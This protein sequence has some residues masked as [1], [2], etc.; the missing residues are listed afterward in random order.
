[1]VV[2]LE[3]GKQGRPG[4]VTIAPTDNMR[5]TRVTSGVHERELIIVG[6]GGFS[7]EAAEAARAA[8][9]AGAPWRLA[10]FVDD[11]EHLAGTEIDGVPVLGRVDDV[12]ARLDSV[13]VV[14]VGRPDNYTARLRIVEH[15]ALAP[16]RYATIVHPAASFGDSTIIGPG[17]VALAGVVATAAVRIGAHVALMPGV[18]LT[19]DNLIGDY[20]TLASGVKLGGGVHI[21][22]GAYLGAG[23]IVR[24]NVTIGPWAMVGMGSIVTRDVP[25]G[26]LWLGTPARFHRPAPV[27]ASVLERVS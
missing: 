24:E 7:R 17:S 12:R 11:A 9:R 25:A 4:N 16:A 18:V 26:E 19:H 21:G 27:S 20:A 14:G 15:L 3:V 22:T 8:G 13:L 23:V 6:A 1:M 5:N 10:G 2:G